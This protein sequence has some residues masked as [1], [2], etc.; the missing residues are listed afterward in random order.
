MFVARLIVDL[1]RAEYA[2]TD[3]YG[4]WRSIALA[5]LV[6]VLLTSSLVTL[7]RTVITTRDSSAFDLADYLDHEVPEGTIIET[8]EPELGFLTDHA[9][10][11][12]PSG[13]LD[14]A[15]RDKWLT[16]GGLPEYAPDMA[17]QP[18]YLVVGPFGKWTGI[19]APFLK[20]AHPRLVA[21]IGEYD[22]YRVQIPPEQPS[23]AHLR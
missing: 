16:D 14:R 1:V 2:A 12:P 10:H 6:A 21:S 20:R 9:Y 5:S 3:A 19:Y 17:I 8:W 13:W 7:A 23:E 11:Y 4:R 22:L 15:V 18:A